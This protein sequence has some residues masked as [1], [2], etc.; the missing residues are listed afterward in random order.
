VEGSCEDC[1]ETLNFIKL[2][3]SGTHAASQEGFSSM[4]GGSQPTQGRP[5]EVAS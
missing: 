4:Q 5:D 3:S 1:N 2:E